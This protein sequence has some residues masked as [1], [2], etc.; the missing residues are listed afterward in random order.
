VGE[1]DEARA[2]IAAAVKRARSIEHPLSIALAIVTEALTPN[3]G[4]LE[5]SRSHADEAVRFC[6]RHGLK[7]FEAWARFALGAV[8][9]RRGDIAGGIAAMRAAIEAAEAL[10]SRLFRP[11]QLATLAGAYARTG[12]SAQALKL[13]AE[14]IAIAQRTKEQQALAGIERVRGEIL[15]AT[16]SSA[17]GEAALR[18]ARDLAQRQGAVS[19]LRRIEASLARMLPR[20]AE[21]RSQPAASAARGWLGALRSLL[22]F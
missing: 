18:Q 1:L 19:E 11:A 16:G 12:D 5:A 2:A 7:N 14:A 22:G 20:P 13:I 4:D 21:A 6:A 9:M 15:L 8:E 3:P 10:G 17:A